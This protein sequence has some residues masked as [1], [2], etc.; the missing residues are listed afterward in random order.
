MK[1]LIIIFGGPDFLF[2]KRIE[3]SLAFY[4]P[5]EYDILLVGYY[6][7]RDF[8]ENFLENRRLDYQFS[9]VHSWNTWTNIENSLHIWDKYTDIYAFSEHWHLKRIKMFF[10]R[11]GKKDG[12]HFSELSSPEK[13]NASLLYL[14]YRT[15]WGTDLMLRLSK[16][17]FRDL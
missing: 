15:R 11:L 2:E 6:K 1:Q 5:S 10:S 17:A 4:Q 7:E 3:A 16:K 9:F 13:W 12:L 14:L 8:F